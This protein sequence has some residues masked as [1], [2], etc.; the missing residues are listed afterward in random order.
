MAHQVAASAWGRRETVGVIGVDPVDFDH[1]GLLLCFDLDRVV[2]GIDSYC[3][4][5]LVS[6]RLVAAR[7]QEGEEVSVGVLGVH[8]VLDGGGYELAELVLDQV[9]MQFVGLAPAL[10]ETAMT[11]EFLLERA[12][13]ALD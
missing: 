1:L 13:E 11:L 5:L 12:V 4:L 6:D 2:R 10:V 9:S 7:A 8:D 3:R